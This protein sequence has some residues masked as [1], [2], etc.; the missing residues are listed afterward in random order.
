MDTMQWLTLIIFAVTI[1]AVVSNV[2]DSTLAG[3]I[4]VPFALA[5]AHAPTVHAVIQ[6]LAGAGSLGLGLLMLAA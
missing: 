4:G 3:L 6:A 1:L 5:A 2:I